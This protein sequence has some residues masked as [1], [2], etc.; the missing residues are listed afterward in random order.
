MS[1]AN[2]LK[3]IEFLREKGASYN[4]KVANFTKDSTYMLDKLLTE[5]SIRYR[6]LGNIILNVS[7]VFP[8][9]PKSEYRK[10]FT[11]ENNGLS[12]AYPQFSKVLGDDFKITKFRYDKEV[13]KEYFTFEGKEYSIDPGDTNMMRFISNH[14][15]KSKSKK[16]FYRKNTF[17]VS[18]DTY[19]HLL[20]EDAEFLKQLVNLP[21]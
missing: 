4:Y 12:A 15:Q 6:Y 7:K 11:E 8:I 1:T 3:F 14:L 2:K 17:S 20:P 9:T 21:I 5:S 16:K 10:I 13:H 19:Y 18:N